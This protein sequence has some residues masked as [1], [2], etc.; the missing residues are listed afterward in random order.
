MVAS[1]EVFVGFVSAER[2]DMMTVDFSG[3]GAVLLSFFTHALQF[4][5]SFRIAAI[6]RISSAIKGNKN[7]WTTKS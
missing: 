6:F 4:A 3:S 2:S 5:N 1:T 7:S